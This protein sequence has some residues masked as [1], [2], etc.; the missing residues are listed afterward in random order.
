MDKKIK[1]H[2]F[3]NMK[4][5]HMLKFKDNAHL[6]NFDI[7]TEN[8]NLIVEHTGEII[9]LRFLED[10]PPL[11]IG[12]FSYS[13]WNFKFDKMI[14]NN[15]LSIMK[16]YMGNENHPY[17]D[18][19]RILSD[20]TLNIQNIDRLIVIHTLILHEDYRKKN[21]PEE[22]VEFIYK[23]FNNDKDI[24]ICNTTPIQHNF[25][26]FDYYNNF[27]SIEIKNSLNLP[28]TIIKA[29]DYYKINELA[30]DDDEIDLYKV[31]GVASRC[32][33]N[34]I[35]ETNLFILNTNRVLNR[36]LHKHNTIY[37]KQ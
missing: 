31:Y 27:K 23:Q 32:G 12:D 10:K 6:S 8:D 30:S 22:F 14:N 1:K 28:A 9:K 2:N 5:W 7:L 36:M 3:D 34:R 35:E 29:K 17:V 25:E 16:D 21:I 18:L 11:P 24:V 15:L 37:N 19:Y 13:I 20:K 26:D 4:L 33:F